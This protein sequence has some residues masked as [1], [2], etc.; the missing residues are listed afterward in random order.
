MALV[1]RQYRYRVKPAEEGDDVA[2][3]SCS[4]TYPERLVGIQCREGDDEE[5]EKRFFN[6]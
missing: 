4:R 6:W 1:A 3:V 2:N 5:E